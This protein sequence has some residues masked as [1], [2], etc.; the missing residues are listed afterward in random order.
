MPRRRADE[1]DRAGVQALRLRAPDR[2][3]RAARRHRSV[4]GAAVRPEHAAASARIDPAGGG[5]GSARTR[6]RLP[7]GRLPRTA[8][9]DRGLRGRATGE[10]R[11]RRGGR[12]SDPALCAGVCRR[13]ATRSRSRA[14][15]PT[16]SFASRRSSRAPRSETSTRCSTFACRPNNPTG[17]L[18]PL[19]DLRPLVVDEAYFEYSGVTAVDLLDDDVIVLRTFSKLFGLAGARIGYALAARETADELNGRQAPAPISTLSAALAVA[20]LAEAPTRR[21][22]SRSES[23][24][25]QVC[26][27]SAS[28]RSN[29]MAT[30]ST[31]PSKTGS[32]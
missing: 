11:A 17:E 25:R 4:A 19:P 28:L 31:S 14:R 27:R 1:G 24:S 2:R 18:G 9:R 21:R 29:P 8:R 6:Q 3:G 22:C 12:R 5:R 10:R 32:R 30:S 7:R 13:P 23:G 15:R 20:A 26:A 16:R